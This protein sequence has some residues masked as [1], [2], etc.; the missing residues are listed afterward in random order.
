[1][2]SVSETKPQAKGLSLSKP[3]QQEAPRETGEPFLLCLY[4]ALADGMPIKGACVVAGIGVS[5]LADWRERE[6]QIEDA[7]SEARECARQKALSAIKAAG[8]KDWRANAE[9]LRLTFPAD[10][11]NTSKIDVTAR[12]NAKVSGIVI[13]AE[14]QRELQE[15]TRRLL[16]GEQ[17]ELVVQK[18]TEQ[19]AFNSRDVDREGEEARQRAL[20]ERLNGTEDNA[21]GDKY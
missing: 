10:Y 6:P 19:E 17:S 13:S 3:Q 8:E 16:Q 11:R 1:V 20:L 14:E 15:R 2:T 18:A 4:S 12:A 7:M 9:W 21:S 5:T